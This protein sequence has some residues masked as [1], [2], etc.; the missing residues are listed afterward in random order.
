MINLQ[1]EAQKSAMLKTLSAA[2]MEVFPTATIEDRL[3]VLEPNLCMAV[4]GTAN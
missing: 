4:T 1:T 2:C 3:T